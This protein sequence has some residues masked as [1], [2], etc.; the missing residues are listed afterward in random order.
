M[1]VITVAV[2]GRRI[3]WLV[4]L[5]RSGRPAEGRTDH[6]RGAAQGPGRRGLRPAQAAQVERPGHR[7]LLHV[8]GLRHPRP[9]DRRG[10]RRAGHQPGLRVPDHRPRPLA[11]LRRGLLRRRRPARDHLVRDQPAAQRTRAQAAQQP[12]LRL[13]HR[14][15]LGHPRHDLAG[16]HHAA[17]LPRR[18]VQ[19]RPLPVRPVEGAV[20]VLGRGQ[21]ARRAA[22][23]TR[24]SR[25]SSCS[26]RW[27]SSSAS[28]SSSRTPSTCTSRPR[29]S[30]CSP[31]ASRTGC[32]SC[33]RSPTT[34]A[35]RSTSPTSRTCPRTPC[36]AR[37]RSRT[38][39]GRA[40][41]TSRPAPSAGA[42]SRSARPGTPASRS[43]RSS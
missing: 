23:T 26:R 42:A 21:A 38:S 5:I 16:R 27:P 33:C 11:R 9:D 34:T 22:P 39:P 10:V 13:A 3:A 7:A 4:K 37:A 32:A 1:L 28:R 6:D 20:R 29:R 30:T 25:R 18:A 36:S 15:G 31:S 14:P 24:A 19:H 8:L 17:A 35:S 41:S 43:R 12:L 40:T 2:A